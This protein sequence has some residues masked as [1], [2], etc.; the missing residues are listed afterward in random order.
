M[1]CTDFVD[2]GAMTADTHKDRWLEWMV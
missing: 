1:N 2:V